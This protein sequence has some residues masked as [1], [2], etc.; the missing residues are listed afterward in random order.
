MESFFL[1]SEL[2]ST[3][4]AVLNKLAEFLELTPDQNSITDFVSETLSTHLFTA[5]LQ[6]L[7]LLSLISSSFPQVLEF[8]AE[9]QKLCSGESPFL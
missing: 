5:V 7:L 9:L 1:M 6:T 3:P 8:D 4:Q 2:L